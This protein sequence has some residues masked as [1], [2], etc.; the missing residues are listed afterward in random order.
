MF[1]TAAL[2]ALTISVYAQD[3]MQK[4]ADTLGTTLGASVGG[5]RSVAGGRVREFERG[6]IFWSRKTGAR[7][8]GSGALEK[9]NE[10]GGASG[11][12]GFPVSDERASTDSLQQT[13]EHG[14]ITIA[15]SGEP[16][17]TLLP[18]VTF[19]EDSLTII[20]RDLITFS[21]DGTGTAVLLDPQTGPDLALSCSCTQPPSDT[22][23]RLGLCNLK[24]SKNRTKATCSNYDCKGSCGFETTD[25]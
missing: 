24:I 14:L 11:S 21:L 5:E 23:Q 3:D 8:V 25:R 2:L 1:L 9:Y 20:D 15:G 16:T 6:A 18:G 13:F 4:K 19:T 17:V 7:F 22:S 12:L 10:L